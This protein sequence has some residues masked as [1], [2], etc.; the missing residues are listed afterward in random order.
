[1]LSPDEFANR[2]LECDE[3]AAV[4]HD[5]EIRAQLEDLARQWRE[6][7]KMAERIRPS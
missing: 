4:A 5:P 2:A 6:L 3:R 7:A 1:M